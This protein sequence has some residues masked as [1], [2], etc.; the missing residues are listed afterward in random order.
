[1]PL[2]ERISDSRGPESKLPFQRAQQHGAGKSCESQKEAKWGGYVSRFVQNPRFT[3]RKQPKARVQSRSLAS[4]LQEA[5]IKAR[6]LSW[7]CACRCVGRKCRNP[8]IWMSSWHFT[9]RTSCKQQAATLVIKDEQTSR[10]ENACQ[11]KT[12]QR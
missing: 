4:L 12:K 10:A 9:G 1:M 11:A 2:G 7:S 6:T 8:S 3:P 5:A